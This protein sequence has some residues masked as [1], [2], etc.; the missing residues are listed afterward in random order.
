M[1]MPKDEDDTEFV[2]E[3]TPDPELEELLIAQQETLKAAVINLE[4]AQ[5]ELH[6]AQEVVL[7]IVPPTDTET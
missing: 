4:L 2:I 1:V 6:T 3:F 7:S 5:Q